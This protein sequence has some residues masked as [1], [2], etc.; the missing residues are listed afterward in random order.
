VMEFQNSQCEFFSLTCHNFSY[1]A[2]TRVFTKIIQVLMLLANLQTC[3][4]YHFGI[5]AKV[6]L[7]DKLH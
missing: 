5:P 6:L 7:S 3:M 1:S 4:P 2:L